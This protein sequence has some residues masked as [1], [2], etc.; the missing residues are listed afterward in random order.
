M[1]EGDEFI[2][3]D[4]ESGLEADGVL[5]EIEGR[6]ALVRL[7][8][9]RPS[10]FPGGAGM[11]LFQGLGKGEK[12][13]WVIREA[14]AL[15]ASR[16]VL[17]LTERSVIRAKEE[18]R[19]H[20]LVRWRQIAIEAARQCARANIPE[21]IGP[22]EFQESLALSDEQSFFLDPRAEKSILGALSAIDSMSPVSLWIGPEGGF[23]EE[24]EQAFKQKEFCGV[25]LGPYILRTELAAVAA[26]SVCLA[27]RS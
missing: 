19:E 23:S 5:L 1:A 26:M 3:F 4:V 16:I 27:A 8:N 17:V 14:T 21:I 15:G 13:D 12:P 24:E 22:F 18:R 20:K 10:P 25:K 2:A 9:V 7:E 6:K 11:T